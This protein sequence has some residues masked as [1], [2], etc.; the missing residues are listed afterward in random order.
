MAAS[1]ATF[2]SLAMTTNIA[3]FDVGL[4]LFDDRFDLGLLRIKC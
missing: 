3:A 4:E 2:A 1:G